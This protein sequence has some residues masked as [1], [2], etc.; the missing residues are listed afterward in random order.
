MK[1]MQPFIVKDNR[2]FVGLE[3]SK[4]TWKLCVRCEG[5]TVNAASMPAKYENLRNYLKNRY[6]GCRIRVMYEAGFQGFWLHDRLKADGVDCIVTPPNKVVQEKDN[7]VKTD[8]IDAYRLAKNLENGD[9]R[10]CHV[11]D[12]ERREDRQI[13]RTLD[14][15]QK[16]MKRTKSRIH[17]MLYY[18]GL[19]CDLPEEK[20]T[21]S[22]YESLHSLPLEGSLKIA[23]EV[24]LEELE[25]FARIRN[26][27]MKALQAVSRKD[28]YKEAVT[29]KKSEP[30]I[31]W[32]SAI[33]F[34]LEWGDLSR[35]ANGK[36]MGSFT[37]LTGCEYS[38]GDTVRRGRIT[39]QSSP[40]I[41]A[42]LIQCAWRAIKCD[43][44]LL[45]KY[46][47]VK[48]HSGS[49]KKA[50][51]AVARKLA[52]RMRAVEMTGMPY[53]PGVIE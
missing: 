2:I 24:Y 52:V 53:S 31:G 10:G 40:Q 29:L 15:I 1:K 50:I 11:P 35:F 44:V 39:K 51:V 13:S 16:D 28:R 7:R 48:K 25:M 20:W 17:M 41:R 3:D 36:K 22:V 5:T 8:R 23:L 19:H 14:Q 21:P 26:R 34:T 27:L 38:T 30:G 46:R 45:D 37:G 33:R 43:P 9:Y 18:H 49:K 12:R 4:S 32:L 6:P 47:R 42:W